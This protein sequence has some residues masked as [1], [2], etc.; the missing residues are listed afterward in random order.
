MTQL[1]LWKNTLQVPQLI[2]KYIFGPW[3]RNTVQRNY[4]MSP[5]REFFFFIVKSFM[6]KMF[7]KIETFDK[8]INNCKFPLILFPW[9]DNL[10]LVSN[11]C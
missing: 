3:D 4:K 9:T 2:Y 1:F 8:Y 10:K 11:I 7:G 6:L 5:L